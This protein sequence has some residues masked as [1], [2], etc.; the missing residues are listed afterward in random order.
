MTQNSPLYAQLLARRSAN[1]RFLAAPAPDAAALARMVM[2]LSH[3]PDHGRLVPFR[4]IEIAEG[5]RSRLADLVEAASVGV[6][7]GL[8]AA[9][10]E[11]T[12]EKATQGAMLL[13][14]V[15]RIAPEHAKITASDQWL[16]VGAALENFLLAAQAEGFG[17]AIRSGRY[18]E[19]APLHQGLG[20]AQN[21]H[22]V[23]LLALGTVVEWPPE[24]P[25]PAREA[26]FS[27]WEG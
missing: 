1:A 18:L 15:A 22:L 7:P 8:S 24:K 10:R 23:S 17:V 6:T 2:A 19:Q 4:L 21:E 12:R 27:R 13:A 25:K 20:L 16:S 3:A 26:V 9:E 14:L 11:R 5:A